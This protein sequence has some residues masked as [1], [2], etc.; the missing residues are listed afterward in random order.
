MTS[1]VLMFFSLHVGRALILVSG[2]GF[3]Q[4]CPASVGHLLQAPV[5]LS[6]CQLEEIPKLGEPRY[7][8]VQLAHLLAG[9]LGHLFAW[10]AARIPHPENGCEFLQREACSKPIPDKTHAV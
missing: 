7:L 10:R 5:P 3:Q 8:H 1:C 4:P 2:Q 9:K 6:C